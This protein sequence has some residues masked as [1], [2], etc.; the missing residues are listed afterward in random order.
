MI[1]R[2]TACLTGL[3]HTIMMAVPDDEDND[4]DDDDDKKAGVIY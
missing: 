4:D 3:N 1:R 2:Q